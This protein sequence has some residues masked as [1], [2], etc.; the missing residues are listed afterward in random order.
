MI[1]STKNVRIKDAQKLRRKRTRDQAGLILVEG[2]RLINDG[3][4]SGHLPQV[5]FYA[6]ELTDDNPLFADLLSRLS[7]ASVECLAC[8]SAALAPLTDTVHTQGAVALFPHPPYR[9]ANKGTLLIILDQIRE[10]GNAGTLLRSAEAAGVE[11]VL[12]APNT[13]DLYNDKVLRSAMGAHFRLPIHPCETWTAVVD[14]STSI[15]SQS[16]T[17]YLA[18]GNATTAY[19]EVDWSEPAVLIVGGEA[20]GAS[21]DAVE[22]AIPIAIP[23]LGQAESLNAAVAGSVILFEAARQRRVTPSALSYGATNEG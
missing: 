14:A 3:L 9:L 17:Y 6:P 1:T 4:E 13:V 20:N 23:M 2:L 11:Q 5:L 10:P 12:V 16:P 22:T 21:S 8:T 18:D 19:D 7:A 15:L